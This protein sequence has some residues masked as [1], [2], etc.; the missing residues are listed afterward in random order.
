MRSDA[1][2][3]E[4]RSAEPDPGDMGTAFGL[5]ASLGPLDEE[6]EAQSSAKPDDRFWQQRLDR[7]PQR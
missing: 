4:E 2:Q 5:D 3:R 7:R 6:P 1:T